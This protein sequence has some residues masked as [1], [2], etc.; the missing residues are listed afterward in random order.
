MK[1]TPI[2]DFAIGE[3]V[4]VV[5]YHKH[6]VPEIVQIDGTLAKLKTVGIPESESS[7]KWVKLV[8]LRKLDKK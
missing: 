4:R 2:P 6:Y 3:R 8:D 7:V 5:G 1:P